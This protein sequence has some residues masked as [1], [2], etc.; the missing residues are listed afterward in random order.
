MADF[1][2]D[3]F[4][5]QVSQSSIQRALAKAGWSRKVSRQVAKE[6]NADIRDYYLHNLSSFRSYHLVY[7]DESGCDRRV[8]FRRTAWSPKGVTPVQISRLRQGQRYQILPAYAQDGIILSRVYPGSTDAAAFEDFIGQLLQHCGKYPNPRSV[9][10]MDNASFH[11][12]ARI[13]QMCFE[14]GVKLVY[15]PPY[16]PDLNPIEEMFAE[17]KAFIKKEWGSYQNVPDQGFDTFLRW[18]LSMVGS[19]KQSAEGHFR[20]AG[21]LVEDPPSCAENMPSH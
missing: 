16:S 7:V 20:H 17:L 19:K 5:V 11:R 4:G 3:D 6:R 12:T 15:L 2:W 1:L 9:L 14:A 18:C 8:G 21:I 10:V 13:Q